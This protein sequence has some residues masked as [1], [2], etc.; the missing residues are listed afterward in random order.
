MIALDTNTYIYFLEKNPEFFTAAEQAI[1][2]AL[3]SGPICVPTIT[4]MEISSGIPN[5]QQIF[6][7]F[8]RQQFVIYDFTASIAVL[9]GDLR[10]SH[11][12]LKAADAIHL[13]TAL[14]N[15]ASQ[16]ITN[17]NRL[18]KIQLDIEVVSL[19]QFLK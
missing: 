12:A 11:K 6:S 15:K 17:D 14:T 19:K 13:A 3:E 4:L 8:D 16:F 5:S 2:Y 7:F 10:Y 18:E 9:A 1:K